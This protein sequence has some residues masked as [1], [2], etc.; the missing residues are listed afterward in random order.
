MN[1][2][3]ARSSVSSLATSARAPSAPRRN[4]RAVNR[5]V[6]STHASAAPASESE[7]ALAYGQMDSDI[8][9]PNPA[10]AY[11][12][13]DE[14]ELLYGASNTFPIAPDELIVKTKLVL[15]AGFS[16]IS[17]SLSQ[18]FQFIGPVVGPLGKEAFV[19]AVGGFDLVTGFPDLKSCYHH[20]RVDPFE[21]NR[22]WFTSRTLGTHN[23]KLAGRFE[24]TGTRVECPPQAL[25]MVFNEEGLVTKITVGVVMDRTLGNT[26]GLGGVFGLFYAIGSP[27][28]FPEARPW[29]MSKRYKFFQFLG[30]LASRRSK[31]SDDE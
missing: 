22:V 12:V 23:G 27:L 18:D 14:R 10:A 31:S 24:A 13:V 6:T 15:R 9:E 30:R 5:R 7:R 16:N 25:S 21:T 28:P 1:E 2:I 26:G 11:D 17:D 4:S 19:N 8:D 29:K 3:S 20:F